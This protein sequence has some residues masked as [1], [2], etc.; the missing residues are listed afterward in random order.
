MYLLWFIQYCTNRGCITRSQAHRK[1]PCNIFA[2]TSL[3]S[4]T[5]AHNVWNNTFEY[6]PGKW[7][8]HI[9]SNLLQ[10]FVELDHARDIITRKSMDYVLATICSIGVNSHMQAI[11]HSIAFNICYN[12]FTFHRYDDQSLSTSCH[13]ILVPPSP[14]PNSHLEG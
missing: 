13:C 7:D 8:K 11:M 3:L 12:P 10:T 5:K 2:H 14:R 6:E 9:I 4:T 1:I